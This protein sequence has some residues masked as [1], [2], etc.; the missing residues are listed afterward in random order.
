MNTNAI[1]TPE[2]RM[3][4]ALL[5]ANQEGITRLEISYYAKTTVAQQKYFT[6]AFRTNAEVDLDYF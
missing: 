5:E 3:Y 6:T 1:F 2:Q 4:K